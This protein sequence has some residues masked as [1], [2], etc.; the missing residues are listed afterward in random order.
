MDKSAAYTTV[1]EY[2]EAFAAD[3]KLRLLQIRKLIKST[4]P[5]SEEYISYGMPSYKFHGILVYFSAFKKHI[6][7]FSVPNL[8]PDFVEKFAPYKTGRG[9]V[10]FPFDK[11]L[12]IDF[13][14]ELLE[15]SAN[16]NIKK[17]NSI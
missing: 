7:L 14:K 11:P 10:Q 2:I 5:E 6:G 8:H 15:F 1:D 4:V 13:I 16:E 17:L 3:V 12:P 9:S